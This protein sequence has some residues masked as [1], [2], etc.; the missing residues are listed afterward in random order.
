MGCGGSATESNAGAGAQDDSPSVARLWNEA[1]LSAIRVDLARPTVHARNLFHSSA[2]MYDLWAVYDQTAD[3]YFLGSSHADWT[4][5]FNEQKRVEFRQASADLHANRE[6]AI[7]YGMYR[8]LRYRFSSSPGAAISLEVFDQLM[9]TLGHDPD[10]VSTD[11]SMG[12]PAALGNYLADCV[13][14]YGLQDGSNEQANFANQ[15]YTPVNAPTNP[16]N[17]GVEGLNDANRWQPLALNQFVDQSGNPSGSTQPFLGA[18]WGSVL[19]FALQDADCVI[20]R[21]DGFDYRV[22]H[23][24]GVPALLSGEGALPDEYRWTHELVALW[25]AHLD[26]AD[27]VMWDISP[28]SIGN[29]GPLPTTI[30]GMRDFYDAREGGVQ[31]AGHAENPVTGEPYAPQFVPRG[32][33]TR[34]LAEFWADG[35]NSETPP[36]HWFTIANEAVTDHPALVRRY[37]G[38]GEELGPL[39]WDVKLYFSLGGAVHDS[40]VTA[41]GIKG[42]YDYIRPISAIRYMATLGQ[43]SDPGKSSYHPEGLP[44]V[45][46]RVEVIEAG[47]PLARD[48]ANVGKIKLWG[49]FGPKAIANPETDVAGVGWMFAENWWPYQRPTFVTPPFAGY[50]SGHSTFSRAAAEVLTDFTGNPFFP[51]GMG[52]F[53]ARKNEFLVFEQGPSVDVTLQWATYRDASDQTSLSRIWGG[54][55]PPVDDIPGRIVGIEIAED[56]ISL[57]DKYFQGTAK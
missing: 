9:K 12:D 15:F 53:I 44:L 34:V 4:C 26:P 43:S 25:S 28:S 27:G 56:A 49:W 31:D 8:L 30:V 16:D 21:R 46:G 42:W 7:S 29:S 1:L 47:D 52:E 14:A 57:A 32:D 51:G 6:K 2:L 19:P 23:D 41:W 22:C 55:H 39:E 11:I 36:G 20:R 40:A 10:N 18:E 5:S 54:I 17:P 35:P 13:I 50:I 48:G 45:D 38:A 3:T 33:Y 24:P 37:R